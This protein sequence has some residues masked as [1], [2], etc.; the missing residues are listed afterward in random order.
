MDT[1]LNT[2]RDTYVVNY[3]DCDALYEMSVPKMLNL[4]E[5]IVG[6]HT[7]RMQIGM[8]TVGQKY[9]V[10]WVVTKIIMKIDK[11]PKVADVLRVST[12]PHKPGFVRFGR[13]GVFKNN[14]GSDCV[15]FYSDWCILD[16]K[17]NKLMKTSTLPS[18][19]TDYRTDK[20]VDK[21]EVEES[22][23]EY[24]YV[25]TKKAMFSDL[26]ANKHVNNVVFAKIA[27]DVFP[28]KVFDEK[29]IDYV[30]N[31]FL[32]QCF[33]GDVIDVYLKKID[34]YNYSIVE[35]RGEKDV[36]RMYVCFKPRNI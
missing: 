28:F 34:E 10:K 2:L 13:S 32:E 19:I 29:Q 16:V 31:E 33:E 20:A 25:Y 26:D 17:N 27:L 8:E 36:F 7:D 3:S 24:K 1:I 30:E 35:K 6:T 22:I 12:W 4:Y 15:R 11:R 5:D 21:E 23:A 18:L 9:G 14:N